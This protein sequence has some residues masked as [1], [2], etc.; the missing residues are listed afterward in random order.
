MS[1]N[2]VQVIGADV[3]YKDPN[4]E[5]PVGFSITGQRHTGFIG[6]AEQMGGKIT[7]AL[8]FE[9]SDEG[10]RRDFRVIF[11]KIQKITKLSF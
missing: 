9:R 6:W 4:H 1:A 2:D 3:Q 5:I 7:N 10:Q 11:Y 8:W